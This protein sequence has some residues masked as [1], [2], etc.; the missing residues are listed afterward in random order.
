MTS[1]TDIQV[2]E[3][4]QSQFPES[5]MV[6][7]RKGGAS[8]FMVFNTEYEI[9]SYVVSLR[10]NRIIFNDNYLMMNIV[11]G[12]IVLQFIRESVYNNVKQQ[13]I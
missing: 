11:G 6:V 13:L 2:A 12:G 1:Y 9:L 5:I 10:S 3:L 4:L 7:V 8:N